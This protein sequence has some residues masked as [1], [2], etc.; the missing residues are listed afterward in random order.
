[1]KGINTL[2][3]YYSIHKFSEILG[4]SAQTLRNWD[5]KGKLHPQDERANKAK[6]LVKELIGE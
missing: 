3:K 1:M 4:V 2:S 5:A 6:K